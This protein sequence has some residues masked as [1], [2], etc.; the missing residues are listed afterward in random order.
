MSVVV[1]T[2]GSAGVGRA[3]AE[4]FA[5]RGWDVAIVARGQDGIDATVKE[6]TRLGPRALGVATDIA[7]A[8]DVE[9]AAERIESELGHID[10]WVNN[11]MT[12]VFAPLE[13]IEPDEF[14]RATEVTYLGCVYGTKAALSRMRP[15]DR[16]V[17]VQVGSALAYRGIPL[18]SAY[19]GAK[20]A[21]RGFTDSLRTEL[22]H[23]GSQVRVTTVH[24]PALNTPQFGW[25]RS[26]LPNHPQP[27]P[28]IYQPEL[29]A[30]AIWWSAHHRRREV[31]LGSTTTATIVGNLFVPGLFDRYLG[32]TG[33]RSQ[34]TGE[35][36]GPRPDDLFA[37]VDGDHGS[38]GVFDKQAKSKPF[39]PWVRL[40]TAVAHPW[41]VVDRRS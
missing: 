23:Q 31:W 37:P 12:T 19:C 27:V 10:V 33:V 25:C 7:S 24:L 28:P 14:K 30:R 4:Y 15:R 18:Q 32:R 17:I 40:V 8:G 22:R 41:D 13:D 39:R 35:S 21:I 1:I 3:T 34:Q 36:I 9:E 5:A 20:H 38:H 2:G 11:A 16:G 29:A 26:K 6:V